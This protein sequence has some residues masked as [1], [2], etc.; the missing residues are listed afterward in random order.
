[1]I[2]MKKMLAKAIEISSDIGF[3]DGFDMA[4]QVK[5]ADLR[6]NSDITRLKGIGPKDKERIEKYHKAYSLLK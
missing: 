1:M 2:T 3:N 6:H 5:K 4:R